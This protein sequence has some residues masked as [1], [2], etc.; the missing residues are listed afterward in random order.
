MEQEYKC[1]YC[2]AK[3]IK[4]LKV[5]TP[6]SIKLKLIREIKERLLQAKKPEMVA[7]IKCKNCAWGDNST[8][9]IEDIY[10]RKHLNWV[11][12]EGFCSYGV[13]GDTE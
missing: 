4:Y 8:A 7:V 11:E 3:T 5:C 12:K 10:C 2:G 1:K 9:G 6:C 13:R